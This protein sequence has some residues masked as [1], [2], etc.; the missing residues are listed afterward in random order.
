MSIPSQPHPSDAQGQPLDARVASLELALAEVLGRV[1]LLEARGPV[2][3][4]KSAPTVVLDTEALPALPSGV[5]FMGLIGKVCLILGGGYFIRTLAE[6]GRL[7]N[8]LSVALGLAYATTW[9]LI[10]LRDKQPMVATFDALASILIAYPLLVESTVRFKWLPPEV[11]APLLL[12]VTVMHATVA[13]R[14]DLQP[15]VWLATLAS[16]GSAFVMMAATHAIEPFLA[17]LLVLGLAT[18]W[19]TYGRRWQDLRW[20][21]ALAANLGVLVLAYLGGWTGGPPEG[22]K[23][24]SPSRA[25][26]FALT[27]V[28]VYIGSFAWRMLKQRR[29]SNTFERI[30]TVLAL[31]VGF[32]GAL[33]L[34]M[35][36]GSGAGMLGIGALLA[37]LGCYAA[38][39][40]F[41][42]EEGETR[43]NFDYFTSLGALFLL[44]GGG[45]VS[46]LPNLAVTA[47][48]VGLVLLWGALRLDRLSLRLQAGVYLAVAGGGSGLFKWTFRAFLD[49]TGPG[50]APDVA[51]LI[52][53]A[54]LCAGVAHYL[55]RPAEQTTGTKIRTLA[56]GLSGM[57]VLGLG[58]LVVWAL[59]PV[60]AVGPADLA[61][62]AVGR[63]AVLTIL[64]IGLAWSA[65]RVSG[66]DLRALVYPLL[67]LATLKFLFEDLA[68][69]HP[70]TLFLAFMFLGTTFILA[71]RLLKVNP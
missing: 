57:A 61:R 12:A 23:H 29:A 3:A 37:G 4:P 68:V 32:G 10:A 25:V 44:L 39:T 41:A 47:G 33:R 7:P 56:L 6:A 1:A 21:T 11:A 31:V 20:P 71:P 69:G 2:A 26:A 62:L 18:L 22:Y 63:T 40:R 17:V 8:A 53:L 42:R 16:L 30:Q 13:W 59:G 36:S 43:S 14:R 15:M 45:M 27:L 60:K 55:T 24:L 51:A 9:A 64:T 50:A 49:P 48:I 54:T 58:A 38:G 70:L 52:V 5:Q 46:P 19:L 34:S 65:R 28:A 66:L 67:A 35:T